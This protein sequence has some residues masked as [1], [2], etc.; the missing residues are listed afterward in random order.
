MSGKYEKKKTYLYK[1]KNKRKLQP[2]HED[3]GGRVS[4]FGLRS[5][6]PRSAEHI[7]LYNTHRVNITKQY[8]C[9]CGN[10]A[11]TMCRTMCYFSYYNNNVHTHKHSLSLSRLQMVRNDNKAT[12]SSYNVADSGTFGSAVSAG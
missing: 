4:F 8:V 6:Q 1:N 5:A 2:A 3:R 10:S 11:A 12:R 7:I 9:V